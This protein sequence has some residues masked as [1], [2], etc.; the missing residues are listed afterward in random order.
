MGRNQ[1][2]W[3][4]L[5]MAPGMGHCGGGPGVNSFDSIGALEQWVEQGQAPDTMMGT[6]AEGLT[7][8]LCPYPQFAEYDGAG[9]LKDAS[10]WACTVPAS[11]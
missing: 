8:P 11:R 5:F 7:R 1:S 2:D 4:R 10:N 9:D 3:M 6:G